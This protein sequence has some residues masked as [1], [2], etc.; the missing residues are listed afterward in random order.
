MK[1]LE[2]IILVLPLGPWAFLIKLQSEALAGINKIVEQVEVP[3]IGGEPPAHTEIKFR[4]T[5]TS[6]RDKHLRLPTFQVV[7]RGSL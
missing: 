7:A 4:I 1:N 5:L 2:I 3:E 6:E